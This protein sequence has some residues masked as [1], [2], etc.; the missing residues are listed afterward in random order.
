MQMAKKPNLLRAPSDTDALASDVLEG[1]R[2]HPKELSPVWFYDEFGSFLFDNI[3][4]LPEY[5][6]TRTELE[7]M[8]V[9]APEMARHIGGN[10]AIIELGSGTSL[11]TRTL[12][13]HVA[14]PATYVPVDIA[15]E[16]LLDAAG[17]LARDYPDLRVIP[18]CA[19]FTQTFE[20]PAQLAAA[21]KRVVYF[22]GS[23]IGNFESRQAQQ[24]LAR[25]RKIIGRDGAVLIGVDLRKD[26][27]VLKRAYD[28]GA[29]VTAEFNLNALRH[30]N[31]ELG[32]DFD[33]DAFE[34]LAVWVEDKSR[35][36]MHLV[37]KR[38]QV[39]HIGD[40]DVEI[41]RGEHLRTEYCHKYTLEDFAT[42]AAA[43]GLSV[44]QVWLDPLERFSVQLLTPRTMQ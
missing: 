15:R 8:R 12:L 27:R 19:D 7:I 22:P 24:L 31:R 3:C 26:P 13:D 23:T 21:A 43:A 25:M 5:Y 1:F 44:T 35:I 40:E 18:L 42:L 4:E 30:M 11:K 28:D 6:I 41:A 37:S 14:M 29:G 34:H 10:A 36:E 20:L 2:K 9:H 38:D 17:A 32:A 33:L 39:V 16:H